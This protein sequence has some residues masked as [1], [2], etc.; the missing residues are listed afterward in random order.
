MIQGRA[1][2]KPRAFCPAEYR[3]TVARLADLGRDTLIYTEFRF[4][5]IFCDRDRDSVNHVNSE[6]LSRTR[7]RVDVLSLTG[8][9]WSLMGIEHFKHYLVTVL[10]NG[11]I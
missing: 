8:E 10:A 2:A 6:Y 3:V 9:L 11:G 4:M 7:V 1:Y 5:W